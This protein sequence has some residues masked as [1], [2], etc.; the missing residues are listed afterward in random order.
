[1]RLLTILKL[2]GEKIMRSL[3]RHLCVRILTIL[4]LLVEKAAIHLCPV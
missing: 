4:K 3:L 2:L 1:M